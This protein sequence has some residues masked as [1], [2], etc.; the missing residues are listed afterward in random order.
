MS[1]SFFT[2]VT[3]RAAKGFDKQRCPRNL[4]SFQGAKTMLVH[5]RHPMAQAGARRERIQDD[6]T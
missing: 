2:L 5:L 3:A 4:F 6:V 1:A